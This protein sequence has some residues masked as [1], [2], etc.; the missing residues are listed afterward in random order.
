MTLTEAIEIVVND[1]R[2][3]DGHRTAELGDAE[4]IDLAREELDEE[5]IASWVESRTVD[6]KTGD[7]YIA[8]IAAPEGEINDL[9]AWMDMTR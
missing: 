5:E 1:Y 6:A 4:V 2:E 7:A 8:V 3:E 9:L